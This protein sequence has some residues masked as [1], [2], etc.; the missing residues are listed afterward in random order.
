MSILSQLD[1]LSKITPEDIEVL[2]RMS[3]IVQKV[4]NLG[5]LDVVEGILDDE[6][7]L[8][9]VIG[10]FTSD[11]MLDILNNRNNLIKLLD[12]VSHKETL[13]DITEVMKKL[14]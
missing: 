1:N 2:Q 4:Q 3:R 6:R 10:L 7:T 9:Q 14:G 12:I 11:T 13:D 5:L 8:K